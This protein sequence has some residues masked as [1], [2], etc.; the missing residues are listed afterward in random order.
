MKKKVIE[1]VIKENYPFYL[2]LVDED[3][4]MTKTEIQLSNNPNHRDSLVGEA[5]I[6]HNQGHLLRLKIYMGKRYTNYI[7]NLFFPG[8]IEKGLCRFDSEGAYHKNKCGSIETKN[9]KIPTPHFHKFDENGCEYAYQTDELTDELIKN[10][11]LGLKIF[12]KEFNIKCND[13]VEVR[14]GAFDIDTYL[15][16]KDPLKNFF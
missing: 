14:E 15:Q 3:K 4:I 10:I 5:E 6:E 16:V 1:P 2:M 7:L 13:E 11:T 8:W 12:C 9:K